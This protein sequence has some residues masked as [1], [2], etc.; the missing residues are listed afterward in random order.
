V[1]PDPNP[2]ASQG[3][4]DLA[5]LEAG[6]VV[7][8][9][10]EG[11][12]VP[13]E[14]GEIGIDSVDLLPARTAV[15]QAT[16]ELHVPVGLKYALWSHPILGAPRRH[17]VG[18]DTVLTWSLADHP[19]R[20]VEDATPK[21]DR[22]VAFSFSTARWEEVARGLR[23]AI[24]ARTDHDA[25]VLGWARSVAEAAHATTDRAKVDAIVAAA[26]LAVKEG[27]PGDLSDI[28]YGHAMGPQS[29]TARGI[30]LD[31]EGS[32]SWLIV[33]ALRELGVAC[34]VLVAENDPFSASPSFPPH[35][36]RFMHPLVIAHVHGAGGAVTEDVP[37]DADVSGPPLPA[38]HVSPELRG[39]Q[40]LHEDGTIA[41]LPD[42]G[43]GAERD[44][45]DERLAVDA[46]GDA[47][48]TFT[49]LLRGRDAQDLAG[50]LER[51]VGDSRQRMLRGVVLAWV[52]YA[53]VDKVELSSTEGSWQVALRAEV[54]VPAYAQPEGQSEDQ[55]RG[56]REGTRR[57]GDATWA[58]PG[59][60]PVHYVYPRGYASTLRAAYATE[61]ARESALAISHAIQYHAHRRVELPAGA[62]VVR[63]PGPFE[64]KTDLLSA[65]RRLQV[66]PGTPSAPGAVEDDVTLGIP[67]G[68]VPAG[69]YGAFV[70]D[71]HR[72]DDAFLAATRFR[73]AR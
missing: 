47:R 11:W 40:A 55:R 10:Y 34:E 65:S 27:D 48:G 25:A 60:E 44:E 43:A 51:T 71:A 9:I 73:T 54:S 72:T 21:M 53:N 42:T 61:G 69:G 67:T 45:V 30:L 56:R 1:E 50:L 20:R 37:I 36:G 8:A 46:R 12:S 15:H 35:L 41:A 59:L 58:L 68:T 49:I 33:R 7:E 70:T 3:H 63:L 62:S 32:R 16:V 18:P 5:Q 6:D 66:A 31:H 14:T 19:A 13:L 24:A 28:L 29:T 26:G 64:V 17:I 2:G 52:P 22:S 23:E 39:R 38:G 4:A 57:E